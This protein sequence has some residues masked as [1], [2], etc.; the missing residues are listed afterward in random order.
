MPDNT[1]PAGAQLLH[2]AVMQDVCRR[3]LEDEDPEMPPP[4]ERTYDDVKTWMER[5][6][7]E[8][9]TLSLW[10]DLVSDLPAPG[11]HRCHPFGHC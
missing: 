5:V 3:C 10:F 4:D 6:R 1:R 8:D 7:K 2:G 9:D 11:A